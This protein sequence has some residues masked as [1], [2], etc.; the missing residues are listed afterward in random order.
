VLVIGNRLASRSLAARLAVAGRMIQRANIRWTAGA[1]P[2]VEDI[3]FGPRSGSQQDH[4]TAVVAF[5][6]AVKQNLQNKRLKEAVIELRLL[7]DQITELPGYKA[8]SDKSL[9]RK[10]QELL[11]QLEALIDRADTEPLYVSGTLGSLIDDYLRLR[12]LPKG[13]KHP[14]DDVV[15][16]PGYKGGGPREKK[17]KSELRDALAKLASGKKFEDVRKTLESALDNL[18]DYITNRKKAPSDADL[19]DVAASHFHSIMQVDPQLNPHAEDLLELWIGMFISTWGGHISDI[20]AFSTAVKSASKVHFPAPPPSPERKEDVWEK[21]THGYSM[22]GM[23]DETFDVGDDY[24][25]VDPR[26]IPRW[27][28]V[29]L[30]NRASDQGLVAAIRAVEYIIDHPDEMNEILDNLAFNLVVTPTG[31]VYWRVRGG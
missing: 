17:G 26:T 11:E 1:D 3:E 16:P 10:M 31:R 18:H 15:R 13:T 27:R 20:T 2:K 14:R 8:S 9:P 5:Q 22:A 4:A 23:D 7:A 21:G 24:E 29:A 6:L 28:T 12:N 30:L 25:E 19:V